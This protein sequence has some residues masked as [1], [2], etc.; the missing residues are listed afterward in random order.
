MSA[1]HVRCGDD[2]RGTLPAAGFDGE[3]LAYVDPICQGPVPA[4]P[5]GPGARPE[6]VG[7]QP[8]VPVGR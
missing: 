8:N 6:P 4:V 1:A 5:A 7:A 3:Y 2:L